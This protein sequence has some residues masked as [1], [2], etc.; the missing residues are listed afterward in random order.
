MLNLKYLQNQPVKQTLKLLRG[1]CWFSSTEWSEENRKLVHKLVDDYI[2]SDQARHELT[3][4][5][6]LSVIDFT[7][8]AGLEDLQEYAYDMFQGS[9]DW[10]KLQTESEERKRDKIE[11]SQSRDLR[12]SGRSVKG[13]Q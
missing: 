8:M 13:R 11:R 5:M 4:S 3:P 10:Q 1:F 6:W 7:R 12:G 9:F 2:R